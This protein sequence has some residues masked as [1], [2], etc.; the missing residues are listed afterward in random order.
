MR[1]VLDV[2][3]CDLLFITQGSFYSPEIFSDKL[4]N[5]L[6]LFLNGHFHMTK[7]AF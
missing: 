1:D 6:E 4:T 5:N 3:S 2:K 7:V